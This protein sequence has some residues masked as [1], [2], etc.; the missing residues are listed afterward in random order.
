MFTK[1][2]LVLYCTVFGTSLTAQTIDEIKTSKEFYWGQGK[3]ETLELADRAA[4]KDLL[5]Q[6]SVYIEHS[7]KH[8]YTENNS[9]YKEFTES[10]TK[11]YSSGTLQRAERKVI[12]TEEGVTVL[13]YIT[14]TQMEEVFSNRRDKILDYVKIARNA[15]NELRI[16]DALKYYYW[17]LA[18]LKSHP[19]SNKIRFALNDKDELV[20]LNALPD[21]INSIFTQTKVEI[22]KVEE[23]DKVK[24]LIVRI[25]YQDR[26]SQNFDFIYWLGD[27]WSVHNSSKNGLATIELYSEQAK[28]LT[29]L[30]LRAEYIFRNASKTDP[31]VEN[32]IENTFI[33]TFRSSELK[34]PIKE[35]APTTPEAA[36]V[37]NPTL[38]N[39]SSVWVD[40]NQ[41]Q[42]EIDNISK[43]ISSG[44]P[45][46][47]KHLFTHEGFLMFQKLCSYGKVK[48]LPQREPL[49]AVKFNN[50]VV[51][52]S[53][54]MSFSFKSNQRVF[55]DELTFTF[56]DQ[57]K[58]A[59]LAF[60]LGEKSISDILSRREE[61]ATMEDKY[62]IIQ[63]MEDYKTA[64]CL[65]RIDYISKIF[66]DNALIIVGHVLKDDNKPLDGVYL[67]IGENNVK[68][69]RHS[70]KEYIEKLGNTFNRNEYV[71]LQFDESTVKKPKKDEKIY[72]IQIAQNWYSSNYADKGYL[73]LMFDLTDPENPMIYVRT[74]QPEKN[75]DG[76][77][78]G[79]TDFNF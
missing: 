13:R 64:Y 19:E 26:V 36:K 33:P 28:N 77:I 76:S 40:I 15:E 37:N 38:S 41:Y 31:E 48:V 49:K 23:R 16:A 45:A 74:W 44:Q 43:A 29:E 60:T 17:A 25:L 56:D 54:P 50:K 59:S 52:R 53:V 34:I 67:G 79:I 68:Y 70:K 1:L 12:E 7:M 39:E 42:T 30:R 27:T 3:N 6:I 9:D 66:S 35:S 18:L 10:V 47:V 24:E 55:V 20:L 51:V 14:K 4:L 71:N 57:K 78:F 73:F 72:G 65:G 58:I 11:T 8:S 32:V 62:Q 61:F 63:F 2:H 46:S 22:T 21:K 5:S 75:K 69:V